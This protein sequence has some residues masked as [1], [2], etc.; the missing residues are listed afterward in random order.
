MHPGVLRQTPSPAPSQLPAPSTGPHVNSPRS[1]LCWWCALCLECPYPQAHWPFF[2]ATL[3]LRLG[4]PYLAAHT[5]GEEHL[6]HQGDPSMLKLHY[7][8]STPHNCRHTVYRASLTACITTVH[9]ALCT[10]CR[11]EVL[12]HLFAS[13]GLWDAQINLHFHTISAKAPCAGAVLSHV[14]LC[15]LMDCSLPGSSVHGIP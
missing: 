15:D 1:W 13:A 12:V 7:I 3:A 11:P 14:Q 4:W 9:Q 6:T 5:A 2:W 8:Q 10:W